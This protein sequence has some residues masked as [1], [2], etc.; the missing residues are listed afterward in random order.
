MSEMGLPLG[1]VAPRENA[2]YDEDA[3]NVAL[4]V[5]RKTGATDNK[6]KKKKKAGKTLNFK[7][8]KV[9][10][11]QVLSL[12]HAEVTESGLI[13]QIEKNSNTE[14][15]IND[16]FE[17]YWQSTGVT[18][19]NDLWKEKWGE[20]IVDDSHQPDCELPVEEL[21]KLCVNDTKSFVTPDESLD[22]LDTASDVARGRSDPTIKAR[23]C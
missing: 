2:L 5:P 12:G 22:G 17:E 8:D 20:Y 21:A 10:N 4:K 16:M 13:F 14:R 15:Q 11:L 23:D 18:I 3:D 6:N 9:V 7:N 1:F 19:L